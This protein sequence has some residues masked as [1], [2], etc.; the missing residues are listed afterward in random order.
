MNCPICSNKIKHFCNILGNLSLPSDENTYE[1][2]ECIN[3][4]HIFRT[5]HLNLDIYDEDYYSYKEDEGLLVKIATYLF[6]NQNILLL[7]P[8][9]IFFQAFTRYQNV[10]FL[11]NKKVLDIG[12]GN[13]FVLNLYQYAGNE[14][15]N[16]EM[17]DWVID[18]SR[19]NGHNTF[20]NLSELQGIQFDFI[21]VNQVLEHLSNPV[22]VVEHCYKLLK[23]GGKMIIGIPNI[24]S[25]SFS[26][27]RDNF[28]QLSFPDHIHFFSEE[29]LKLLLNNFTKIK[30]KYPLNRYNLLTNMYNIL[31]VK[32]GFPKNSVIS[33]IMSILGLPINIISSSLKR[34]HFIDIVIEL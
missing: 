7:K 3:C 24:R 11:R 26:L 20:K 33:G 21:R 34:S 27:F 28:D 31:I 29:S 16:I 5:N 8:L 9:W 12:G 19:K 15:Y 32:Y 10:P 6:L 14:T 13:G 18:A 22:E 2:K 1:L 4:G 25:I 17:L 23:P 30:I